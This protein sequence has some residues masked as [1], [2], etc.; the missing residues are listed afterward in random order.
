MKHRSHFLKIGLVAAAVACS[1]LATRTASA[2]GGLN[3]PFTHY[4]L[5][6]ALKAAV[7]TIGTNNMW[8]VAVNRTGVVC[9]VAFSGSQFS[10]QWLLSRQVAAAKAF[11]SNGLS[12]D[13]G[14]GFKTADLYALVQPGGSLF[15]LDAGNPL[16]AAKAYKGPQSN[17]GRPNDPMVGEVVGGTITFGGGTPVKRSGKFAGAVGVSGDTAANDQLVSDAVAATP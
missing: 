12:T 16:D 3:C 5:K 4:T 2:N 17:W 10:D 15:G 7:T 6:Q 11:T 9:A 1:P 14:A 13:P 8:A